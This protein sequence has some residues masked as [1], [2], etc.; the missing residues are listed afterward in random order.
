[1]ALV[2]VPPTGPFRGCLPFD[3]GAAGVFFG[4]GDE[5]ATLYAQV[6]REEARVTAVTGACGVGKTSLL[7]AALVPGLVANG[8]IALYV[9]AGEPIEQ[10]LLHAASRTRSELPHTGENPADYLVRLARGA[11]TGVVVVL[12]HLERLLED[13]PA[14]SATGQPA[15]AEAGTADRGSERASQRQAWISAL[16]P[17]LSAVGPKLRV[18]LSIDAAAFHRIERL[19]PLVP[20]TLT[21]NTFELGLL[22]Q[23]QVAEILEQTAI[24]TGT[25]MEA[26][27][28]TAI[29]ADLCR[30]TGTCAP[31]ELQL[32]GR[33]VTDLRLTSSRRYERSGGAQVLL[34]GLF[35]RI[36]REAGGPRALKVLLDLLEAGDSSADEIARRTQLPRAQIDPALATFVGRGLLGKRDDQRTERFGLLHPALVGPLGSYAAG[37]RAAAAHARRRLRGRALAGDRLTIPELLSVRRN[38]GAALS[39]DEQATVRRST[40]RAVFQIGLSS[41]VVLTVLIAVYFD[42]RTSY[43]LALA[44]P[45]P[46]SSARV[47]VKT[48]REDRSYLHFLPSSPAFGS[49]VADTGFSASGLSDD[50]A[51]RIEAGHAV[52][53]LDR[54]KQGPLPGW[55]AAVLAG[56][57]PVPRGVAAA[58][59]GDAGGIVSLKQ[60]FADPQSRRETLQALAVIG[61]GRAG[62]DEILAAALSDADPEIRRRGVEVAAAIDRRLGNGSHA[63]TLRSALADRASE[64]KE[65][66]LHESNSLPPSEQA[67]ILPVALAD[68][69]P[70]FRRLAEKAVAQLAASH[71]GPAAEAVKAAARSSDTLR[72]RS[73]LALLDQIVSKNAPAEA[74]AALAELAGDDKAPEETRV[75]ALL[76]LR[77]SGQAPASLA[78]A[79]EQAVAPSA[80]PRL[81][82]AALPLHAKLTDPDRAEE[83]A[84]AESKGSASSRAAGAAVWGALAAHR[85]DAA[86]KA[87][88]G[89]VYDPSVEVRIEATRSFAYLRR[90]GPALVQ[91]ALLDANP[92][93]QKAAVDSAVTLA[94]GNPY[95][96]TD[97][98][99]KAIRNVRPALRRSIVEALA[100]I[101]ESKPTI[102]AGPLARA[103]KEADGSTREAIATALCAIARKS[104]Q[105]AAPYLRLAARD[106]DRDVRT[107]AAGCLVSL[108][109]VD[110]RG[111]ARIAAE[112][113]DAREASVRIAAAR[114]L[115]TLAPQAREGVLPALV[116]LLQD[117]D[118]GVRSAALTGLTAFGAARIPLGRHAEEIERALVGPVTKGD[119]EDRRAAVQVAGQL[120][121][122][123]LLRQAAAD[124]D[125]GLRLDA[126]RAA[127]A[128]QP[129]LLDV[130]RNATN[131]RDP[132]VRA[133]SVRHLV[134]A[135]GKANGDVIGI[136]ERMLQAGDVETR[137]S[138]ARALG[139]LVGAEEAA[140]PLLVQAMGQRS[141]AVRAAAVDA[142]GMVA[143]RG[144]AGALAPLEQ[145]LDDR[146]DDVR[147]AA[148][149]ALAETWAKLRSPAELAA[150]IEASDRDSARRFVAL[151]ALVRKASAPE[152]RDE[153][154]KA[155][156]GVG[157]QGSPLARLAAEIG[158]AFLTTGATEMRA[159]LGRLLG[160]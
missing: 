114:A 54:G 135:A 25:F 117:E 73:G 74:A 78:P 147:A 160:G 107:A 131:D 8:V 133:E 5:L 35:E 95:A 120:G 119:R 152:A 83:I 140:T 153:V 27:L 29:A 76:L 51:K 47:V 16:V 7:R 28:A 110:A 26:G 43:T 137:R 80:S 4:R 86:A 128:V 65:A 13:D 82:A 132:V 139:E 63:A 77:R 103:L 154:D 11:R 94:A 89:M 68:A 129:P 9:D 136:F 72:R 84:I 15:A 155:L 40:R 99:G 56:L 118:R 10:E 44:P 156:A 145:A 33:A 108:A 134:A 148:I 158:R 97:M 142:L 42:L 31:L 37:P 55:M 124:D 146:A 85:P 111:A 123:S 38:L 90:E 19:A 112:L 106:D 143:R 109:G 96:V 60:A 159:F 62:E 98:L 69:D 22:R 6:A 138:G 14:P 36:V 93:V 59:L 49:I 144:Q 105:T 34:P 45:G 64:V 70:G 48:G 149:R 30:R 79:L 91:K 20:S 116:K 58:L 104:P 130:L 17:A 39:P 150:V 122:A 75:A 125:E 141:E 127:G 46:R 113:A 2:G 12:D 66:V 67:G 151:E 50:L 53:K 21:G 88:K 1:M 92:E 24:Q 3:E 23:T 126:I 101:G 32:V 100:R 71:P 102:V 41:L 115:G 57:R 52:G 157:R 87:L 18:V 81:R 61:R 121:L